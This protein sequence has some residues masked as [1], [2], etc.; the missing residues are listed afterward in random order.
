MKLNTLGRLSKVFS[1]SSD[2][3][4]AKN[5]KIILSNNS[6]QLIKQKSPCWKVT[7]KPGLSYESEY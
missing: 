3:S 4:R 5:K 7:E 1:L 2:A 6:T